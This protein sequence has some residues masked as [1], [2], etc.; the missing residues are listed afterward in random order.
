MARIIEISGPPGT[1][2]TTILKAMSQAWKKGTNWVPYQFLLPRQKMQYNS[3]SNIVENLPYL[4]KFGKTNLDNIALYDAGKKFVKLYPDYND[5]FWINLLMKQ[6]RNENGL[7]IRFYKSNVFLKIIEKYQ[8]IKDVNS[9][10][11][12]LFDEGLI[13]HLPFVGYSTISTKE[14]EQEISNLINVM[15]LPT[16]YI[17][18]DTDVNIIMDRLS[19]RGK[20]APIHKRKTPQEVLA[21]TEDIKIKMHFAMEVIRAKGVPVLCIDTKNEIKDSVS[22]IDNFVNLL[23]AQEGEFK[24]F[25]ADE[26]KLKN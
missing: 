7:D 18:M 14:I 15:P 13:H 2:K 1:G 12:A 22:Q 26:V 3:M 23:A 24:L 20:T 25:T 9:N 17:Y 21:L 5:A 10:Q 19:K 16:A 6:A 8:Y 11:Y 4:I